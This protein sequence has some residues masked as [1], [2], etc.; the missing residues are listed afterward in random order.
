[1]NVSFSWVQTGDGLSPTCNSDVVNEDGVSPLCS[2]LTDDGGQRYLDTVPWLDE[3]MNRINSVR[4]SGV[5]KADW[6]RDAWGVELT[7]EQAKIYSL[8]DENYFQIVGIKSF[9]IALSKWKN[10]IQLKPE[11]GMIL[12]L[13]I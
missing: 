11:F 10:F 9:E 12:E 6:S 4:N 8:Q 2:L 3:G 1:M 7:N 13:E 5:G